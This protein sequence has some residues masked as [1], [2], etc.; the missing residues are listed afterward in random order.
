M[1][2]SASSYVSVL[3]AL[4]GAPL[5]T[6][7]LCRSR[8]QVPVVR[9]LLY[10]VY[11]PGPPDI[12]QADFEIRLNTEAGGDWSA[13]SVGV[14]R[15]SADLDSL[16]FAWAAPIAACVDGLNIDTG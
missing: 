15:L 4:P 7:D 5:G 16:V 3:V 13:P 11:E 12:R 8:I 9:P 6:P 1:F 14:G 10:T 2:I